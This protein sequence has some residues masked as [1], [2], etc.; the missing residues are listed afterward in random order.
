V[1]GERIEWLKLILIAGLAVRMTGK[2]IS[3]FN[4]GWILACRVSNSVQNTAML[5]QQKPEFKHGSRWGCIK[6]SEFLPLVAVMI[7]I[8]TNSVGAQLRYTTPGTEINETFD[9]LPSVGSVAKWTD[10]VTLPG[11]FIVNSTNGT[12]SRIGI[13]DGAISTG[14]FYSFGL[15]GDPDR[16]LGGIAS[17]GAYFG[18]PPS[19]AVA[20]YWG[21]KIVNESGQTLTNFVVIYD[22]EQWRNGGGTGPHSLVCEWSLEATN[23]FG[24][25]WKFGA[26]TPSPVFGEPAG[27]INGN[28]SSNRTANVRFSSG[29]IEWKHNQ[30]LWIRFRELNDPGFDHGLAIDNFRF[31]A[32]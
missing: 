18:N 19:G 7:L 12:P 17:G 22:V 16:A 31:F 20:G 6:G 4:P 15:S 3:S 13:S 25:T 32:N 2:Q 1:N 21:V 30:T 28:L 11:W 8:L 9:S 23:W 5:A 24:G 27:A 14:M 10:N 26:S 29:A